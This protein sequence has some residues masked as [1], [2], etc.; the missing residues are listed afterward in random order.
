M[1]LFF[2][3]LFTLITSFATCKTLGCISEVTKFKDAG[4]GINYKAC[5]NVDML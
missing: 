4:L 2:T 3:I 5:M 1:Y